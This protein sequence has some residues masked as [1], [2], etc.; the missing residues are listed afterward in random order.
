[1]R[2]TIV[3]NAVGLG[4]DGETVGA[5]GIDG[6][7][8]QG[9]AGVN[10]S[11]NVVSGNTNYGVH[12][13]SGAT[14]VVLHGNAIGTDTFGLRA[15][16]N[17]L[18]GVLIDGSSGNTIGGTAGLPTRNLISGN[19]LD[20]IFIVGST[21]TGNV[22]EGNYIGVNVVGNAALGNNVDGIL[23]QAPGN[24]IGG[25]AAG[26][27]NVIS[28][29]GSSGVHSLGGAHDLIEG[30]LIG[31]DSTGALAVGNNF[32][33]VFIDGT[34][35]GSAAN[36]VIGGTT[37]TARN[38]IA[39]NHVAN[40]AIAG[41][42]SNGT[43]VQ[44]NFI[45]T[46]LAGTLGLFNTP[47]GIVLNNA[48][49]ETI[50]GTAAGAGNT[51]SGSISAGIQI[52]N[53]G[54]SGNLVQGQ[55]DRPGRRRGTCRW[56]MPSVSSSITRPITP[57]AG[58]PPGRPTPSPAT[59]PTRSRSQAP[60]RPGTRSP[61]SSSAPRRTRLLGTTRGPRLSPDGRAAGV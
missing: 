50:G 9:T 37:S 42:L 43:L 39:G 36:D 7:L 58:P 27:A 1:M 5:N 24:T 33:G 45:G 8:V 17:G 19:A 10:I 31:T 15:K 6:I 2:T 16:G 11:F 60:A 28:G 21:A 34:G 41:P 54:A 48:P 55:P 13:A 44:G 22:V 47:Y 49:G 14:G 56:R 12:L 53:S 38:V 20:G 32:Y 57:S 40:I 35:A 3:A 61:A 4:V 59:R 29:N 30:N 25:T 26:A 51:I 18:A 46:N 23:V 52:I